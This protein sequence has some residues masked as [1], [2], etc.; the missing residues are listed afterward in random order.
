[1]DDDDNDDDEEVEEEE[2]EEE[3]NDDNNDDV[4][5][6]NNFLNENKINVIF[7]IKIRNWLK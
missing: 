3:D 1:M 6:D 2:E 4:D 5:Y 7:R